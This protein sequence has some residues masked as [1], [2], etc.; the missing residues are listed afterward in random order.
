MARNQAW[1]MADILFTPVSNTFLSVLKQVKAAPIY[2]AQ[3][4]PIRK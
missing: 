1:E 2:F 4:I 3:I